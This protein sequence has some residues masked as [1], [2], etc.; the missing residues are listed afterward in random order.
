MC[1]GAIIS[2]FIAPAANKSRRL[3]DDLLRQTIFAKNPSKSYS[4]PLRSQIFDLEDEFE[5]DFLGFKDDVDIDDHV[6]P[7]NFSASK[8]SAPSTGSKSVKTDTKVEKTNSKK[9]KNQYRG[10][11][12]RPWGKWAAEIRDPRK[13]VRVWLGTFNTAEEAARAYD[14]EAR[15]I[16]GKKA[17]VNFPEETKS[18]SPKELPKVNPMLNQNAN[19]SLGYFEQKPQVDPTGDMTMKPFSPLGGSA[20]F[21]FNSDQGS[22]SFG[23]SDFGWGEH[24]T[25][26]EITSV[27]SEVDDVNFM[28][29]A[30]PST[31]LKQDSVNTGSGYESLV[32]MP[33]FEGNWDTSSMDAFLNGDAGQDAVDAVDL[34]SFND[35]PAIMDGSF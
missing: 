4:K 16:R 24:S 31:E 12:Q 34:W 11:R 19:G 18:K 22:N 27:I 13:G 9:R 2:D 15:R 21:Q 33:L 1:G 28:Q 25:T 26:P 29:N 5:A 17:K 10:I 23:C 8:I 6:T 30:N 14:D 32:Q 3:T 20:C 7:F 35:M